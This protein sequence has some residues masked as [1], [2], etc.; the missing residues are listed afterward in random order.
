M[1]RFGWTLALLA[2]A[3]PAW[4]ASNKKIS[5][6]ELKDQLTSLHSASKSD[7]EVALQ[8]KQ[9]ELTE[10]L[11]PATMSSFIDLLPGKLSTEQIYVLEA[12]SSML[13]PPASELPTAPAP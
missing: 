3:T 9:V 2:L 12:R 8:L 13:V 5:V 1:K 7:E 11:T 6:Q 10:E 4:S